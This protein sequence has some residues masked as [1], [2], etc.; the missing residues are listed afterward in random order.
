M[1][2]YILKSPFE[3]WWTTAEEFTEEIPAISTI[4]YLAD[5]NDKE[6]VLA[7]NISDGIFQDFIHIPMN[8]VTQQGNLQSQLRAQLLYSEDSRTLVYH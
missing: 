7:R 6:I 1:N 5:I 4:G 2:D 8:K 3:V